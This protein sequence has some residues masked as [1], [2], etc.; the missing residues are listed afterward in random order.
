MCIDKEVKFDLMAG[1]LQKRSLEARGLGLDTVQDF[2][3]KLGIKPHMHLLEKGIFYTISCHH[4]T[5]Q[6]YEQSQQKILGTYLENKVQGIP[7]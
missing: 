5:Y 1:Q 6:N 2:L 4:H 3:I 7:G